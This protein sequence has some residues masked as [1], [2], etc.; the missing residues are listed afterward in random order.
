MR[1]DAHRS[2]QAIPV[3]KPARARKPLDW[4]DELASE[5]RRAE[6]SK[7]DELYF[8]NHY[9]QEDLP[10]VSGNRGL[11]YDDP[12]HTKRFTFL[13]GLVCDQVRFDSIIDIGCGL[14]QMARCFQERGIRSFAL[15]VSPVAIQRARGR[16]SGALIRASAEALP[17]DDGSVDVSLCMDVL[18]HL[19]CFDVAAA[20]GELTRIARRW[21]IATIN[22]DN[23]Y[24]YHPT[25]L[26]RE[27]W[28]TMFERTGLVR[29]A[30]VLT[31]QLQRL[32]SVRYPEYEFFVFRRI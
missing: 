18:E 19:P 4:R 12:S 5:L 30:S 13:S 32:C 21:V 22:L 20:V 11:S 16:I 6:Q 10:G 31:D 28:E 1:W 23:P 8:D 17:L 24:E 14:G 29:K 27:S 7:Y 25:I 26:S 15:D 2:N 3:R 9:W